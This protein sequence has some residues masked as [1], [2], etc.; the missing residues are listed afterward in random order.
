VLITDC[1]PVAYSWHSVNIA[2][3]YHNHG[4]HVVVYYYHD[5][6]LTSQSSVNGWNSVPKYPRKH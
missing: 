2:W 6:S 5:Y 1:Y 3:Y 4:L